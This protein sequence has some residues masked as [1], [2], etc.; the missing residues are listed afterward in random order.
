MTIGSYFS[1]APSPWVFIIKIFKS[2]EQ[3]S[4]IQDLEVILQGDELLDKNKMDNNT[5]PKIEFEISEKE[6]LDLKISGY[7][8]ND[9]TLN[10]NIS[11]KITLSIGFLSL[12]L[13]W[14]GIE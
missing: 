14:V 3:A 8:N 9:L 7:L 4:T 12:L 5:Y 1:K 2:I 10:N 6:I 11:S 13:I